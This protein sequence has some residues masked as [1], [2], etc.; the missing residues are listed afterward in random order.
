[1]RQ[2]TRPFPVDKVE[3]I[4]ELAKGYQR[5]PNRE[6]GELHNTQRKEAFSCEQ[7]E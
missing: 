4:T 7:K 1:M 5:F 6:P 2:G 3:L